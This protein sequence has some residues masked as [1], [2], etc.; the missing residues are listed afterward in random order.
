M[1]LRRVSFD[2]RTPTILAA[3]A[4]SSPMRIVFF[5]A[6]P[7][8][9]GGGWERFLLTVVPQLATHL[10]RGDTVEIITTTAGFFRQLCFASS[11]IPPLA[12]T[13]IFRESPRAIRR[14]LGEI[15]YTQ[16]EL[17]DLPALFAQVD[18]IY[19]TNNPICLLLVAAFLPPTTRLI[20]GTHSPDHFPRLD[21]LDARIR[22]ATFASEW[23]HRLLTRADALHANN[24]TSYR[25]LQKT[26]PH[27][28]IAYIPNPF[29]AETF[30]AQRRRH[31]RRHTGAC[32]LL[33]LGRL[34]PQKGIADLVVIAEHL[35]RRR[36][37]GRVQLTIAGDGEERRTVEQ[38][39]QRYPALIRY[40]GHIPH[41]RIPALIQ[42]HDLLLVTSHFESFGY[43]VVES[44]A[45]GV[46]AL[47]YDIPGPADLITDGETGWLVRTPGAF[48]RTLTRII[49][50]ELRCD[51]ERIRSA[52]DHLTPERTI[53]PLA[54]LI[55]SVG[56]PS[57]TRHG[58]PGAVQRGLDP[59]RATRAQRRPSGRRPA[60]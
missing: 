59:S 51:P 31:R 33:W 24:T 40:V 8:E 3:C 44:Q 18:V 32:R 26:F 35:A 36:L 27:L 13:P 16:A 46:P 10:D 50:G 30:D 1:H 42:R 37:A 45:L 38:L 23:Y 39:V 60:A 22:K 54:D 20:V 4:L 9:Y 14:T 58:Q 19:T 34:H 48:L 52:L 55:R 43:T 15:T 28:P 12:I 11:F 6:E 47:S 57:R 17:R 41:R 25:Q 56:S 21:T 53:P 7:L 29:A 49:G 2:A 5:S